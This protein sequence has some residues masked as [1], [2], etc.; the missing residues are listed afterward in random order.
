MGVGPFDEFVGRPGVDDAIGR[1]VV[2]GRLVAAERLPLELPRGVGVGVDGDL[3][4]PLQGEIEEVVGGGARG[5]ISTAVSNFAQ[6]AKTMSASKLD[7]IR[8]GKSLWP[9]GRI[10]PGTFCPVQ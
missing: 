8:P 3:A 4:P 6:A 5:G 10:L 7:P 2:A 1:D 9:I